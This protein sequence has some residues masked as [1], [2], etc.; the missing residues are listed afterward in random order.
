VIRV[1]ATRAP[2]RAGTANAATLSAAAARARPPGEAGAGARHAFAEVS[3]RAQDAPAVARDSRVRTRS[4]S[5][6]R[7]RTMPGHPVVG[8]NV[9]I[10]GAESV[11][12]TPDRIPP[13][14]ETRVPVRVLGIESPQLVRLSVEG[15]GGGNGT[16]T[17]DDRP[18]VSVNRD[19]TLRLRGVDQTEEGKAAGLRLV[20][21]LGR[22]RLAQSEPFSIAAWPV[23][24]GFT[25]G[26]PLNQIVDRTRLWGALYDLT[27]RSDSGE[28]TDCDRTSITE[29]VVVRVATGAF[30]AG[31]TQSAF[32]ATTSEQVDRHGLARIDAHAART[33]IGRSSAPTRAEFHQ[34][35]RFAC[36]RSGV[37]EDRADGP[38]VPTSG[39]KILHWVTRGDPRTPSLSLATQK[40]GFVNNGVKAGTVNDA[41]VKLVEIVD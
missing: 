22:T 17:I 11:P 24:I 10:R 3:V 1:A 39:F 28:P 26:G 30:G 9:H 37:A 15:A 4:S 2:E 21:D 5:E 31:T 6:P 12:G 38:K 14:V 33:D 16:V 41:G 29:N 32:K 20:A 25:F 7:G 18:S 36:A 35:F 27:F 34:F 23:E 13:R 8:F 40:L 19:A